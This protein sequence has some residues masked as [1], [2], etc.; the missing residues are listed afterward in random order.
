M[1]TLDPADRQFRR[2]P[3][4]TGSFD[5]VS[6]PADIP[7]IAQAKVDADTRQKAANRIAFQLGWQLPGANWSSA[8]PALTDKFLEVAGDNPRFLAALDEDVNALWS[9]TDVDIADR[10]SAGLPIGTLDPVVDSVAEVLWE[11][12]AQEEATVWVA[13]QQDNLRATFDTLTFDDASQI[14]DT[15]PDL[16]STGV[17]TEPSAVGLLKMFDEPGAWSYDS[18]A[19]IVALTVGQRTVGFTPRDG[20]EPLTTL[21]VL[22]EAVVAV[23]RG[24]AVGDLDQDSSILGGLMGVA[25]R[26]GSWI[27]SHPTVR[28]GIDGF[29]TAARIASPVSMFT[30]DDWID[31]WAGNAPHPFSL[32]GPLTT[33]QNRI[34]EEAGKINLE[35]YRQA[36]TL[37][38]PEEAIVAE[39]GLDILKLAEQAGVEVADPL[40]LAAD[41]VDEDREQ[42]MTAY[43]SL[44]QEELVANLQAQ[45]EG[46]S[47]LGG[48]L[49]TSLTTAM[50]LMEKWDTITQWIGLQAIHRSGVGPA[51]TSLTDDEETSPFELWQNVV[52]GLYTS[53]EANDVADYFGLE[54]SA[55]DAALLAVG[56]GFDPL[57]LLFPGAKG[58]RALF[59]KAMVQPEKYGL[60]Y[61]SNPAVR[62]VTEGIAAGGDD[63]LRKVMFLELGQ[64]GGG[65]IRRL[66]DLANDP[67]ATRQAVDEVLLDAM[68]NGTFLGA[69]PNRAVRMSTTQGLARMADNLPLMKPH[70]Q[71]LIFDLTTQMGRTKLFDLGENRGL[72]EFFDMVLQLHGSD[73]HLAEAWARRALDAV[74][75][76]T[77]TSQKGALALQQEALNKQL[78]GLKAQKDALLGIRDPAVMRANRNALADGLNQ[79]DSL[80]LDETASRSLTEE[81]DSQLAAINAEITRTDDHFKTIRTEM[82]KVNKTLGQTARLEGDLM[83]A[84]NQSRAGL[85]KVVHEFYDD[86][87]VKINTEA[88]EDLIPIIEGEFYDLAPDIPVRDWE[89][90]TGAPRSG[91]YGIPLSD[92]K[93][94]LRSIN[95]NDGFAL[96]TVGELDR[97]LSRQ[98]SAVNFFPR[99]Q[100]L[101]LPASAYEITLFR[102]IA[103]NPAMLARWTDYLRTS[104]LTTLTS[105]MRTLFGFN[106]L[107]NGVTPIKTTADETFRFF[108]VTGALGRTIKATAA[109]VPG[110]QSVMRKLGQIPGF[111]T[112]MTDAGEMVTNPFSLEHMRHFDQNVRSWGW[113][114]PK[115]QG[116][117]REAYRN[118]AER[119]VNGSLLE[120]SPAFSAYARATTFDASRREVGEEVLPDAFVEWWET[121]GQFLSKTDEFRM[122]LGEGSKTVPVDARFAYKTTHEA[123]NNWVRTNV[124]KGAQNKMR[125]RLLEAAKGAAPGLDVVEDAD[126]LMRIL[127]VP[128]PK[129]YTPKGW[130][131]AVIGKSFDFAFGNPTARRSGVFHEYFFD[132]AADVLAQR[133][134]GAYEAGRVVG[135]PGGRIL[136]AE[137]LSEHS[138]V[139]LEVAQ[140]MVAQG[141]SNPIVRDMVE[142]T[143]LRLGPQLETQAAAYASRRANDLMYR[144]TAATLT[145]QGIEAGLLFPYARAQMDFLQWWA[146]HLSTPQQIGP[147]IPFTKYAASLPQPYQLP[148]NMRAWGKYAHMV[149]TTNNEYEDT[150]VDN[151]LR[152]LTFFPLRF[153]DEF[154]MDILPQPGPLPSWMFD[155][156]L[157]NGIV[158]EEFQK[159]LLTLFPTLA[160]NESTGDPAKDLFDATFPSTRRSLRGLAVSGARAAAGVFGHDLD[161]SESWLAEAY[162]FLSGNQTPRALNDM[163]VADYSDWLSENAFTGPG[164]GGEDWLLETDVLALES[165]LKINKQD[166][167]NAVIDRLTPLAGYE[168]EARDLKAYEGLFS[169]EVWNELLSWGVLASN[170]LLEVDGQ[171][172]IKAIYE[173]YQDGNATREDLDFLGDSLHRIYNASSDVEL[174]DGSGFTLMDYIHL[175]NPGIAPNR[176][177]K[178]ECSSGKVSSDAHREFRA[179]HCDPDTGRLQNIPPGSTGTDVI[180]DARSRGWI[181]NRPPDGPDGWMLDAHRVLYQSAKNAVDAV[182]YVGTRGY[183]GVG[184]DDYNP[185]EG[186]DWNGGSTKAFDAT[187]VTTGPIMQR[188]LAPLGVDLQPGTTMTGAEFFDLLGNVR[189][190][191]D[192]SY[193]DHTFLQGEVGRSLSRDPVGRQLRDAIE[194]ARRTQSRNDLSISDWPDELKEAVRADM[195]KMIDLGVVSLAD[196]RS[197]WESYFGPLD[198]EPPVPPSVEELGRREGTAGFHVSRDQIDAGELAV[199]DGDTLSV[200]LEDGPTRIR[201]YGINAPEVGQDGYTE[202]TS[203]LSQ[204]LDAADEVVIGFFDT[205]TLGLVQTSAPGEQRLI[206][207]LYVNGKPIYDPSVFTADNPRGV[208]VGGDVVD[209]MAILNS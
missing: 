3:T 108:A 132:E 85:A 149:S 209:L 150:L 16:P 58:Q 55:A 116:L 79:I 128:A 127:N 26:V 165:A 78:V 186:R 45:L 42:L 57:N 53:P 7:L 38:F 25:N 98:L 17:G 201:L 172:R 80:G 15:L 60:H 83:S 206:G 91:R 185:N 43:Q 24:E 157:E 103:G 196:Y 14:A 23:T 96:N 148:I 28:E 171:P 95:V 187:T 152:K 70:Q 2:T 36:A 63:A 200:L 107:I 193:D 208:G 135:R 126:L 159:E 168:G 114:N 13:E 133:F 167:V 84:T 76:S 120:N 8:I 97:Q 161:S 34:D 205:E 47:T 166:G 27:D 32:P 66:F 21:D 61:L 50:D 69:G 147:N 139:P 141:M 183:Q 73:P 122:G 33:E 99:I 89:K 105:R 20:F 202:A 137:L 164:P 117:S 199:I 131:D 46:E 124:A 119:W 115:T 125:R 138:D 40:T 104:R 6:D 93:E 41:L 121:E 92:K 111:K 51:I 74:G 56:I 174:I 112:F 18:D 10:I 68:T 158:D 100:H 48:A 176:V 44:D 136:T 170:E 182:W 19:N 142:K 54:G 12:G 113:V 30:V 118:H 31:Y 194:E 29:F 81:M 88:G 62:H 86:I 77:T 94:T 146:K 35:A 188:L 204:V 163:I 67:A 123:F 22:T 82:A 4:P 191:Y 203:Q 144:Y 72:D 110:V 101:T 5:A 11:V 155:L 106:L 177:V 189:H 181:V 162:Q 198:Y 160:F 109:G 90:V 1:T 129:P 87:A 39:L 59:R 49:A 151:A 140:K 184:K 130:F 197:E 179:A 178:S 37:R 134:G 145:G 64:D 180:R 52:S 75:P 175:T 173:K 192:I 153:D 207:W 71:E 9:L 143:G 102:R 65:Y 169:D 154:L 190:Q 195:S 156:A